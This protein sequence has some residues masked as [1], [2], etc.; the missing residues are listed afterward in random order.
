MRR[1]DPFLVR[2]L[3]HSTVSI[4][5]SL[6]RVVPDFPVSLYMSFRSCSCPIFDL[7]KLMYHYLYFNTKKY[8]QM[9]M[10]WYT[11]RHTGTLD[12]LIKKW[13]QGIDVKCSVQDKNE[14]PIDSSFASFY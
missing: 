2:V 13:V 1:F 6:H 4:P 12:R 5:P 8:D 3:L 10:I 9:T 11:I 14:H 7:V